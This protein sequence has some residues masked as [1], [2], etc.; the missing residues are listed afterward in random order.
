MK[1][2]E[3][4]V[5]CGLKRDYVALGRDKGG[6]LHWDLYAANGTLMTID[7]ILPKSKGGKNK[8]SNYQMMC[9]PCNHQKGNTLE[10]ST[11]SSENLNK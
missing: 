3:C 5:T 9:S 7:H 6:N 8:M 1:L 10:E 2:G 4:C 11:E